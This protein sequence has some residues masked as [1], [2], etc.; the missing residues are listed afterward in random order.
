VEKNPTIVF[1]KPRE[2][3]IENREKPVLEK[4]KLL[5]RTRKTLISTGTELTA[6]S[7]EFRPDSLWA[8]IIRYPMVMGYCNVG[9]VIDVGP[10]VDKAWIGQRVVSQGSHALYVSVDIRRTI[11]IQ[12]ETLSDEQA[13]FSNLATVAMNGVRRASVAWGEA[14][15]VYGLGLLGQFT[16]RFSRLCGARPVCAVD[17]A[18]SRL[19]RLPEDSAIVRVNPKVDDVAT[20]VREH[21]SGRMA[22]VVFEVTGN[23]NV[24]VEE[25]KCL[26]RQGRLVVVSSPRGETLFDF[27]DYCN[28]HSFTIIGAHFESHP[29][30]PT[31]D[32]P[33]TSA[34]NAELFL[35]LVAD[36]ELDLEPLV[37]HREPYT[38]APRLYQELLRDRSEAMGVILEWST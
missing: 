18:E 10:E 22:D 20:V 31:A 3:V 27:C 1:T 36:G 2:A 21:T 8:K 34:R 28:A 9:D 37:S 35:D 6:L 30:H 15:A 32:N 11:A 12:R 33:W 14:V 19:R 13:A 29:E 26:K 17:V 7:G 16:V 38:E 24:I 5:V 25:F 23:P 4:G